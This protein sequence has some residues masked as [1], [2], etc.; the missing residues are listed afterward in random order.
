VAAASR[1]GGE[2]GR[3]RSAGQ[4]VSSRDAVSAVF[5]SSSPSCSASSPLPPLTRSTDAASSSTDGAEAEGAGQGRGAGQGATI[6]RRA[7]THQGLHPSTKPP[8]YIGL[9]RNQT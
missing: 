4:G 6:H 5:P 2:L 3:G 8:V 1:D 9:R 7:P